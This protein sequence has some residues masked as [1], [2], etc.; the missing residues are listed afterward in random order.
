M[1]DTDS[2]DNL[3]RSFKPVPDSPHAVTIQKSLFVA[4]SLQER[5]RA[6]QTPC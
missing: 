5:A 3:L 6:L 1:P 4:R 2:F